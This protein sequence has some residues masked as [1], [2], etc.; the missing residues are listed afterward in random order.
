MVGGEEGEPPK[1]IDLAKEVLELIEGRVGSGAFVQ[2]YADI[3]KGAAK[4][5]EARRK[6]RAVEAI[7][8]PEAAAKRRVERNLAKRESKK[9]KAAEQRKK[10]GV[11]GK[12]TRFD[13]PLDMD[14]G[15]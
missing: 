2:A 12:R 4:R 13:T 9:R 15:M 3:Q 5:R 8:D 14:D 6:A 7:T 10:R 1:S 11:F